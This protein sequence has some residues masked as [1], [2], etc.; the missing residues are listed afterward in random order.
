M[1]YEEAVSYL[2]YKYNIPK[3]TIITLFED[4]WNIAIKHLNNINIHTVDTQED[5]HKCRGSVN[6]KG[7]GKF[8]YDSKSVYKYKHHSLNS[9]KVNINIDNL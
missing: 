7:L 1:T 9:K 5:I 3:N 4:T 6:F 8:Y 2:S